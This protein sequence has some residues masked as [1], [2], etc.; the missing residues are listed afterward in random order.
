MSADTLPSW[1]REWS[2][3]AAAQE[4]AYANIVAISYI[5]LSMAVSFPAPCSISFMRQHF[6]LALFILCGSWLIVQ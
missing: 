3:F 6:L 5:P 1:S 2:R 4:V